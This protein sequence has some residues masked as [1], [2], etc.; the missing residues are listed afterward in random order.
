[1]TTGAGGVEAITPGPRVG[2]AA[3]MGATGST[4]CASVAVAG[5]GVRTS[6]AL[7]A[8]AF[9]A[10]FVHPHISET[11]NNDAGNAV[12]FI[13]YVVTIDSLSSWRMSS[14]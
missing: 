14:K 3:E 11:T 9:A 8:V 1:M 4:L 13:A 6:E 2:G 12:C 5:D 10:G 7:S